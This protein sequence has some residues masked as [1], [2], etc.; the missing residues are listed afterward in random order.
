ML[1]YFAFIRLISS[2]AQEKVRD[3]IKITENKL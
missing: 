2:H 3:C 1:Q